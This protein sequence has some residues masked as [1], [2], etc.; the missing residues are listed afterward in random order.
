[1]GRWWVI[2]ISALALAA[3]VGVVSARAGSDDPYQVLGVSRSASGEEIRNAYK[4]LIHKFAQGNTGNDLVAQEKLK[5]VNQ[6]YQELGYP[7]SS[8]SKPVSSSDAPQKHSSTSHNQAQGAR[9]THQA[10]FDPETLNEAKEMA[11]RPIRDGGIGFV[12]ADAVNVWSEKMAKFYSIND[13]ELWAIKYESAL[14]LAL[15]PVSK[16]GL[17]KTE[18]SAAGWAQR[19]ADTYKKISDFDAWTKRYQAAL[20]FANQN[21]RVAGLEHPAGNADATSAEW[22]EQK[23]TEFRTL[24]DL[25]QKAAAEV[26]RSRS[27]GACITRFF[28]SKAGF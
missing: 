7:G 11:R 3:G 19:A 10:K 4:K 18:V 14:R 26:K 23:A 24:T 2:T 25:Q 9:Q 6:A 8:K 21:P 28:N 1:M 12:S 27:I 17:G 15:T 5:R 22:A 20:N 13:F 16:G